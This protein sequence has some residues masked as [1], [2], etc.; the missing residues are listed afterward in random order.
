MHVPNP[1]TASWRYPRLLLALKTAVAATAAWM[2]VQPF[3]GFVDSYPYYGPLGAVVAMS[4][5]VVESARSATQAVAAILA[6]AAL[7]FT[8]DTLPLPQP[9]AVGLALGLGMLLAMT[10]VFGVMAGW[11]P[12]ATLFVLIIGANNPWAYAAAYGGLTALGAA[13]GMLVNLA[14]PQLPLTPAALAQDRLRAQLSDQMD[15]LADGLERG[16]ALSPTTGRSCG[17]SC[18]R[19]RAG[20]RTSWRRPPSPAG[21]TGAPPGGPRPWT[22]ARTRRAPCTG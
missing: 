22:G 17:S 6:G 1:R 20:P 13:V 4:T 10:R 5:S 7:A 2:L 19:R 16:E 9:I 3:G 18:G 12:F 8:V 14:W 11:V 15:L 21:P